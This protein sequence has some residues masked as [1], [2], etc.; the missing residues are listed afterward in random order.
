VG[1]FLASTEL[2]VT[3]SGAKDHFAKVRWKSPKRT[4]GD[5]SKRDG[6]ISARVVL[7]QLLYHN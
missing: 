2:T 4:T 5:K 1:C 7:F 6:E 3:V